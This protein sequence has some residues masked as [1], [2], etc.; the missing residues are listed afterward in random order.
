M[1]AELLEHPMVGD[2]L[3][4]GRNDVRV[5]DV[6]DLVADL[7][8]ALDVPAEGLASLLA[9]S[10]QVVLGEGALV[11]ALEVCNELLAELLPRVNG[12]FGK[13][14]EPRQGGILESVGEPVG[15]DLVV[16]PRSLDGGGV[17]LQELDGV[18][19]AVV[20]LG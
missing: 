20:A 15:H 2:A 17:E 18:V 12:V 4:E 1:D 19:R 16:S 11:R 5:R 3:S 14:Q 6:R 10:T 7:A 8:E 13:V 9:H